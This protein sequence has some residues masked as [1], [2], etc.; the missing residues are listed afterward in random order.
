MNLSTLLSI[1]FPYLPLPRSAAWLWPL[2]RLRPTPITDTEATALATLASATVAWDTLVL[3]TLDWATLVLVT[4]VWDTPVWDTLVWDT[5]D[6][7]CT[8]GRKLLPLFKFDCH[9]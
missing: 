1:Q 7:D 3:A 8:R 4:L 5:L 6:T 2:L 9:V